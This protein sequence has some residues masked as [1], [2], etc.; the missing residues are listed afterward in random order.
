MD[1]LGQMGRG[2]AVMVREGFVPL[3]S[4]SSDSSYGEIWDNKS[5]MKAQ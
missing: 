5:H 3:I 1:A 4:I 2:N